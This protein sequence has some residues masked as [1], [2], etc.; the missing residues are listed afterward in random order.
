MKL[1]DF[2]EFNPRTPIPRGTAAP[3][4]D[5]ASLPTGDRYFPLQTVKEFKGSGSKF[6]DGDTLLARITPCLENGK[7]GFV[8]GLGVGV[9]AHGS[10]EFIVLRAMAPTDADFVFYIS[11]HPD[12]RKHAIKQMSGTS[13]RQ[14]VAW[15]SLIEYEIH[16]LTQ[17]EREEIGL[18][19]S[20]L[21]HKIELNRRMNETLEGMAQAIFRDWFVDFGP[22]HRKQPGTIDPTKIMGGLI[23]N[24]TKAKE[25]ADLFPDSLGDDGLPVGWENREL[26]HF[27]KIKHGYA[28]KGEFFRTEESP[29][30]LITPGNFRIGGGFKSNKLKYY[31]GPFP[32]EYVLEKNDLVMT[33]TDLSKAG[34]TLGYPAFIPESAKSFFL[35]NQR[36]GKVFI[37]S[38]QVGAIFLY[39]IFCSPEYR[40]HILGGATGSTV[41]HTS[42][43]KISSYAIPVCSVE[44]MKKFEEH[45]SI[46]RDRISSNDLENQALTQI[47]D[48]L[49]PK[50]MSGEIRV[51][52]RA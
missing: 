2:I 31:D 38:E 14:R 34:D 6:K 9:F 18:V 7:G 47:R 3:F 42:P 35:H 24:E 50:L 12:F 46:L 17:A 33:M 39:Q 43:T 49:L 4:V 10:T 30:I 28:F 1:A 51:E 21:D 41:K 5:M 48:Y 8:K 26:S 15:Q 40:S 36:I 16:D 13:G 22:T 44:L 27:I 32:K 52:A 23:Q 29:Y 20:V 37:Q 45:S 25:I 19:L 11:K